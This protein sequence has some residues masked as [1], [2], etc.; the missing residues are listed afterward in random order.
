MITNCSGE[1]SFSKLKLT[2]SY[3][4]STMSQ[5]ILNAVTIMSMNADKLRKLDFNDVIED[6]AREKARKKM[7]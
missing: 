1:R 5:K 3:L 2:K 7:F 6:F 4:R